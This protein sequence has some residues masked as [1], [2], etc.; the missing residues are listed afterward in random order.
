MIIGFK[1]SLKASEFALWNSPRLQEQELLKL[2]VSVSLLIN[3][4][5]SH[6]LGETS[7]LLEDP[8]RDR[9]KDTLDFIL[10]KKTPTQLPE[11]GTKAENG[12][13]EEEG[14]D[15]YLE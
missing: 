4:L 14:D 2:M 7:S 8:E 15:G 5:R 1:Q 6:P 3:L 9:P 11:F 12:K 10:A 13:E